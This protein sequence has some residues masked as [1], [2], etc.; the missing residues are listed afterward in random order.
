M[1][2]S[3]RS[4]FLGSYEG[5][6]DSVY[7]NAGTTLWELFTRIANLG[8]KDSRVT[9]NAKAFDLHFFLN[10]DV[11]MKWQVELIMNGLKIMC[12]RVEHLVFLDSVSF[13]PFALR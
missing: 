3:E 2:G 9:H 7:D 13:F 4:E 1:S 5:Q 10:R 12:M 8:R 11:L 6:K